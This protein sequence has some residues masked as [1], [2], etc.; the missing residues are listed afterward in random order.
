MAGAGEAAVL[1]VFLRTEAN[2]RPRRR[3]ARIL[4]VL[5]IRETIRSARSAG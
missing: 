1:K 2:A 5:D 3:L 4:A